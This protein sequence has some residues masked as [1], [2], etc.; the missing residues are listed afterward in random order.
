ML[1]YTGPVLDEPI[2][3]TGL[4]ELK[5]FVSASFVNADIA[6][7]LVAVFPRCRTMASAIRAAVKTQT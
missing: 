5:V 2:K 3:A 1:C 7:E 4:I 6:A